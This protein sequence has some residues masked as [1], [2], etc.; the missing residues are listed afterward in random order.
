M[1]TN[2]F[3]LSAPNHFHLGEAQGELF[4]K[5]IQEQLEEAARQKDWRDQISAARPLWEAT[6]SHFPDLTDEFL[7][8]SRGANVPLE[9]LW[10]LSIEDE[11]SYLEKCTTVVTNQGDTIIHNEDWDEDAAESIVV[12][13]RTLPEIETLE[14]FYIG[15]LGGNSISINSHGVIHAVNSL[16]HKRYQVGVPRN[17][18]ARW[19]SLSANPGA[20]LAR[21]PSIKRASGYHHVLVSNTNQVLSAECT[22]QEVH[23]ATPSLPF[24][25]TNHYLSE[26]KSQEDGPG[27]EASYKRFDQATGLAQGQM[28]RQNC[29]NLANYQGAGRRRSIF[30]QRTIGRV[31]VHRETETASIWLMRESGKGW[32]DYRLPALNHSL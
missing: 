32:I 21:F 10:A 12:L 18:I 20:D 5:D 11:L 4:Q 30:N 3:E 25:H 2:Y 24:V 22:D 27:G 13:R 19:L 16:S 7:G 6:E 8:Y 1:H 23:V 14:L 26:L 9:E 15:T 31:I 29:L 17:V 28:N